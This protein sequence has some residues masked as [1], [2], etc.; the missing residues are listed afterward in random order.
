MILFGVKIDFILGKK[1][2]IWGTIDFIL[3]TE[4]FLPVRKI[5]NL[6]INVL[7]WELEMVSGSA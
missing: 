6:R 7:M 1:D 3:G 2:P 4:K 5:A